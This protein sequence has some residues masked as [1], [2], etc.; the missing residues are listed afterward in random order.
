MMQ[1]QRK[2]TVSVYPPAELDSDTSAGSARRPI[3]KRSTPGTSRR[4]TLGSVELLPPL[5]S[6]SHNASHS[7]SRRPSVGG[8]GRRRSVVLDFIRKHSSRLSLNRRFSE[9][10]AGDELRWDSK[11]L[12]RNQ[13]QSQ[14]Q[15]ATALSALYAKLLIILGITLPVTELVAN[16]APTNFHQPF[17]LY[18]YGVSIVLCAL[19]HLER[20]RGHAA[21]APPPP[22]TPVRPG[23]K[24][25][26]AHSASFY[27]RI[28]A[29]AFGVGS[30][31]YSALD[32]GQYF[33]LSPDEG[34]G[35]GVLVALIPA[36]RMLL[37]VIQMQFIIT[38]GKELGLERYPF[39]A[40]FGLMHLLATN[41]CEWLYVLVEEAKQEI[42][43]LPRHG[44]VSNI[45]TT[46]DGSNGTSAPQA[47]DCRPR[48]HIMSNVVHNTAPFLFPCTIEYSLICALTLYSLWRG[49]AR[50]IPGSSPATIG[51]GPV[52]G[53]EQGVA[54][55]P[56][57]RLSIDCSRA[58]AGLLAGIVTLV[59]TLLVLIMHFVLRKQ[60]HREL[61]EL[62]ML[63]VVVYELALYS[64]TLAAVGRAMLSMRD[65][66]VL[67]QRHG[68][69]RVQPALPLDC[70]LLLITQ[71]GIY[72]Y[73]VFSIIGTYHTYGR[74]LHW[75]VLS[76]VL[77]LAQTSLQTLFVLSSWWRRCKGARQNRTKPGRQ[78]VTFLLVANLAAWLV[79]ALVKSHAS[80]RPQVM[81][82][83]GAGAWAI[84]AHVSMPLAIFYRFHS[85]ICLFEIW[86]NTYKARYQ[87]DAH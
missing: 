74:A 68:P 18:L 83:Y 23:S 30:L 26:S 61:Q 49:L 6:T 81:Q 12:L 11:Q 73:G 37:C 45:S 7:S 15:L 58:Q 31:V 87:T 55:R 10:F 39:T 8:T 27:L 63:E 77:A 75:A 47:T 44:T 1:S 80:F 82:F 48:G 34:C 25:G 17:Y 66:R 52:A 28:G 53:P 72:I 3:S 42:V 43:L 57:N 40:R 56:A 67:T 76:E 19:L 5:K 62:A 16:Q 84:I 51:G 65:L 32:F 13:Q 35:G 46:V 79:N 36:T 24:G 22:T 69:A 20:Y 70:H 33:E 86:K 29:I 60:T 21:A 14:A 78:I 59:V 71:T 9:L 85:T 54:G 4:T 64:V 41:V 38:S 2:Q 50:H